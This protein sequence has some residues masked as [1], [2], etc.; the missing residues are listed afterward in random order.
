MSLILAAGLLIAT[1]IPHFSINTGTSGVSELPDHFRAKQGLEVLQ[2]EVGFGLNTPAG[3]VLD[4]DV[5]S[6][7]GKGAIEILAASLQ[8]DS[9]FGPWT[10]TRNEPG[11]LAVISA[12]LAAGPSTEENINSVRV[13]YAT[14]TS[15]VRSRTPRL[16]RS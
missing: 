16:R 1:S 12:P 4:G 10:V 5:N 2:E 11:D 14:I 3:I 13:L 15:R 6:D 8:S 7:V 9:G